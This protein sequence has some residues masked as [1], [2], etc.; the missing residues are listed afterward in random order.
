MA[1]VFPFAG[2]MPIPEA[3]HQVATPPYDVM[4]RD[5]AAAMAAENPLS[6]LHVTRSEIDLDRNLDPYSDAVYLKARENYLNFKSRGFLVRDQPPSF[7]LYRLVMDGRAQTGVV[8]AASVD[9]YD[10]DIIRKH[11]KTRRAKED[12]RTRHILSVGAQ[13]GP[14]FLTCRGNP[15]LAGLIASVRHRSPLLNFTAADGI[16]HTLW[17]VPAEHTGAMAAAFAAEANLYIAD[18]HHRAASAS[19]VRQSRRD[20][21]PAHSGDEEYN[22]FLAVVFPADELS[23]LPYNRVVADLADFDTASFLEA[24]AEI[25]AVK[26]GAPPS[27]GRSGQCSM[28]LDGTWYGLE[29]RIDREALPV[30]DQ[31]D[32]SVLQNLILEPLLNIADPRTSDRIDFVGGIRGTGELEKRVLSGEMAVAFSLFS[33]TVGQLMAISDAGE[34]MPPKST[35]FEPKLRDAMV[36]HEI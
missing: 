23:I 35:W 21:N 7:Y 32:V 30:I 12:D 11:E 8:V 25:A 33:T 1:N 36:I 29:F 6:F 19:R 9:D 3:A 4:S 15:A 18:G 27:P 13:T 31:L 16:Q 2:V 26:P 14:V 24:I 17:K 5:E 10:Q 22:R 34:I 20:S 28:F